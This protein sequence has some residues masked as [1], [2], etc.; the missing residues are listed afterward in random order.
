MLI[1]KH[2]LS[3]SIIVFQ[4]LQVKKGSSGMSVSSIPFRAHHHFQSHQTNEKCDHLTLQVATGSFLPPQ[5]QIIYQTAGP[6]R[7]F[8]LPTLFLFQ[9]FLK[10][11][12]SWQP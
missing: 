1:Q 3:H 7:N 8:G 4:T 5:L 9:P 11:E 10:N 12:A 6:N 2:R